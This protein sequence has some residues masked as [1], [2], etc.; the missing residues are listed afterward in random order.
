MPVYEYI[1][2]GCSERTQRLQDVG[3]DSSGR[4]C[5]SCGQGVLKKVFSVFGT[6]ASQGPG[7]SCSPSPENRRT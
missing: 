3:E 1:C 6:Q 7:L 5:L 2:T 4:K